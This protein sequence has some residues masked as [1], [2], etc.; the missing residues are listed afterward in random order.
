[1][2]FN[3][4]EEMDN[5][6]KLHQ[7]RSKKRH[8]GVYQTS[9]LRLSKKKGPKARR[10]LKLLKEHERDMKKEDGI[11]P[12]LQKEEAGNIYQNAA[13]ESNGTEV[14]DYTDYF[15]EEGHNY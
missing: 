3:Q 8:T 13:D 1:M 14:K 15:T 12:N 2:S 5:G 4:T 9:G 10:L 7:D 11:I 6:L